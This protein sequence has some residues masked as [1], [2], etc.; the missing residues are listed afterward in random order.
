MKTNKIGKALLIDWV[1]ALRSG[2]FVQGKG[3]LR[4]V[5]NRKTNSV[6]HCCLGVLREIVGDNAVRSAAKGDML[7][8]K[9]FEKH[10]LIHTAK[11]H[12]KDQPMFNQNMLATMNDQGKTFEQIAKRIENSYKRWKTA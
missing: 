12:R 4:K 11:N 9:F 6:R 7:T 3:K 1:K 8:Q 10:G 2:E 5:D